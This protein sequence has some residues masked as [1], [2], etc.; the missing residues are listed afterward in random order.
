MSVMVESPRGVVCLF[1]NKQTCRKVGQILLPMTKRQEMK[2]TLE[3]SSCC[4]QTKF[5]FCILIPIS[6]SHFVTQNDIRTRNGETVTKCG[7][8]LKSFLGDIQRILYIPILTLE[9]ECCKIY[10]QTEN[11][12]C[13]LKLS[14]FL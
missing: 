13:G 5:S 9:A 6:V 3:I 14:Q 4:R 10:S 2:V 1:E 7:S 12:V 11:S 8:R